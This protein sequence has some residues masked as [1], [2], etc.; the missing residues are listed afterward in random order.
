MQSCSFIDFTATPRNYRFY[1][2]TIRVI[3][4]GREAKFYETRCRSHGQNNDNIRGAQDLVL[5]ENVD[6]GIM[7][8]EKM[9]PERLGEG[10]SERSGAIPIE[11][12]GT[13]EAANTEN[14]TNISR[15]SKKMNISVHAAPT[16]SYQL[17]YA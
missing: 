9:Q 5:L 16:A 6:R 3:I 1:D 8:R 10:N 11:S 13:S 4:T 2:R 17:H 7:D 15:S 14:D 12:N